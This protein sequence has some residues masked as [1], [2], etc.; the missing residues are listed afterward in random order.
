MSS[1]GIAI[2]PEAS[3]AAPEF[4]ER[5]APVICRCLRRQD[6]TLRSG[7]QEPTRSRAGARWGP[8]KTSADSFLGDDTIEAAP[9][10]DEKY[11]GGT[12]G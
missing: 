4:L 5:G 12:Y 2:L 10:S 3:P 9:Q 6:G 7:R 11:Q 1:F 8:S